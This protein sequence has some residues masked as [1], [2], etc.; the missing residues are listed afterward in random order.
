MK[1]I[2]VLFVCMGNICRSPTAHGI[3]QQLVDNADLSEHIIVE[4]AG[5]IGY[6]A[7]ENPD[8][9]ATAMASSRSIDISGLI[10][11]KVDRTDFLQQSYI[12]AMDYDNLKNL[13]ADCPN[14][15]LSKVEL[16]LNYHP[17]SHLTEVPDPYY[18]GD[19]G[20]KN[21]YEMV[22]TA[23]VNLLERIKNE[24]YL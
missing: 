23:C 21:V 1:Q 2:K 13:H 4:S 10:A 19:N 16:L 9:R 11:R 5:T 18:G 24:S 20:F 15:H 7:G 14:L 8:P 17:D 22:E 6:H 3:F 12:L